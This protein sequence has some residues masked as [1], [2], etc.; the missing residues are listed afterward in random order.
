MTHRFAPIPARRQPRFLAR[1][2]SML[3]LLAGMFCTATAL[4]ETAEEKGLAIATDADRR[5]DGFGDYSAT[6]TMT[7]RA[8][9]GQEVVRELRMKTMEVPGDGDKSLTLFDEPRDVRGTALLTHAHKT[10]DDDIWLYLPALKRVKRIAGNNKSG[11]FMGSEFAFE[12]FGVQELEKY[13][14]KYLREDQLDGQ[15]CHVV[16]RVPIEKTSGYS[17]QEVWFD[18]QELRT[19]RMDLFNKGG[20]HLKTLHARDYQQHLDQ[21]WFPDVYEMVNHDTGRSTVLL[22]SNYRFR[23]G[24]T[25]RDFDQNALSNAR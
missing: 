17:R 5:L 24:A 18:Q 12:D 11:P 22:F 19:L 23:E 10:A 8:K 4:A 21:F 13:T 15:P 9:N 3:T 6:L 1:T 2:G 16:E 7:L 20:S 25:D 14:Y